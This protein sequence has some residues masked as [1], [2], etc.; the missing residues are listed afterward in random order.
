MANDEVAAACESCGFPSATRTHGGHILCALCSD[1]YGLECGTIRFHLEAALQ[2]L[3]A[4]SIL[5]TQNARS[6]AFVVTED[7]EVLFTTIV[8]RVA[9]VISHHHRQQR[10]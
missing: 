6:T 7:V 9:M 4:I 1:V 8:E 5:W 2:H 10:P 3:E